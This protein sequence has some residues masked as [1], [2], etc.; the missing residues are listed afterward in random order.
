MADA[1]WSQGSLWKQKSRIQADNTC[2]TNYSAAQAFCQQ[3]QWHLHNSKALD[4]QV[5][6][7]TMLVLNHVQSVSFFALRQKKRLVVMGFWISHTFPKLEKRRHN[8]ISPVQWKPRNRTL[9]ESTL[10]C[11]HTFTNPRWIQSIP[12]AG[13]LTRY[14]PHER[15]KLRITGK[16]IQIQSPADG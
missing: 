12:N 2:V 4:E 3:I 6:L 11:T 5:F 9:S 16:W 10:W 1:D 8:C 14:K 15:R 13:N 7:Q